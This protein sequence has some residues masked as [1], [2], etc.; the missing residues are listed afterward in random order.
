MPKAWDEL[1]DE[2]RKL[3]KVDN[4]TLAEVMRLMKGKH[5]FYAS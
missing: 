1:K 2:I 4:K 5:N 3:Y